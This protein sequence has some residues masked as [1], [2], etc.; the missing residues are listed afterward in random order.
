MKTKVCVMFLIIGV[1]CFVTFALIKGNAN[2]SNEINLTVMSPKNSFRLGEVVSIETK[3]TNSASVPV[4]LNGNGSK[5]VS[6]EISF[7][8]NKDYK[9]YISSVRSSDLYVIDSVD[10]LS[11]VVINP[12]ETIDINDTILWNN[13]PNAPHPNSDV[14]GINY[15]AFPKAG[16]YFIKAVIYIKKGEKY[17]LIESN[18]IKISVIEPQGEELEVWNKIKENGQFAHFLQEGDL[19][20]GYHSPEERAKFQAEVEDIINQYPNSFYANSLRQSLLKFQAN[21]AKRKAYLE[22]LKQPK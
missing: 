14:D 2:A 18:Q 7:N 12:Q 11:T 3:V 17:V 19:T 4:Y 8:E 1:T 20:R 6:L 13:I 21:E 22:K 5:I 15:Y 9:R 16:V 10:N